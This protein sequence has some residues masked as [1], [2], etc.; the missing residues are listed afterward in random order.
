M[1]YL[2]FLFL[3]SGFSISVAEWLLNFFFLGKEY[4]CIVRLH[5]AIESKTKL[6]QVGVIF[7]SRD[8]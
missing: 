1:S 8:K 2:S 3:G 4:V 5:G 7:F 6:A